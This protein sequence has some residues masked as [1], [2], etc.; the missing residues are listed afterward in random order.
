MAKPF[1][2]MMSA[3]FSA[4]IVD[5]GNRPDRDLVTSIDWDGLALR[6]VI[7]PR[8]SGHQAVIEIPIV[9][10]MNVTTCNFYNRSRNCLLF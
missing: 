8:A 9:R 5:D 4:G 3:S 6:T 2:S 7:T 1:V 10:H